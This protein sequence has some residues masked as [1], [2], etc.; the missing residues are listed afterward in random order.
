MSVYDCSSISFKNE[1]KDIELSGSDEEMI[2]E[3]GC[4]GLMLREELMRL[5][6][7]LLLVR[8]TFTSEEVKMSD[9]VLKRLLW[10]AAVVLDV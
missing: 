9:D 5:L 7:L 10:I 6:L 3:M 4:F 8:R 1:Y 2:W